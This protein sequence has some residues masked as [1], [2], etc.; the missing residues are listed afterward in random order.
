MLQNEGAQ[1]VADFLKDDNT[2]QLV[3]LGSRVSFGID[4]D[5]IGN[6][7][8]MDGITA[9]AEA[10]K[11]NRTVDSLGLERTWFGEEAGKALLECFN[12]NVSIEIL[13]IDDTGLS[14]ELQGNLEFLA[15]SRNRVLI[16]DVVR[17]A[18]L[19]LI[20]ARRS[21]NS[22]DM[23]T[24]AALPKDVVR[25]IAM[26]VWATNKDPKWIE[27]VEA[28]GTYEMVKSYC[29]ESYVDQIALRDEEQRRVMAGLL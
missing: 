12:S 11:H 2:L 7:L 3:L 19:L 1:V 28:T 16:P 15:N 4:A 23:G 25:L 10:L 27:A 14:P 8:G 29:I 26:R 9:L 17:E 24:L 13:S 22:D 20:L 21:S 5:E 6:M 18:A